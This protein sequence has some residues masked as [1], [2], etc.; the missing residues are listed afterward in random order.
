MKDI[1][2]APFIQETV[3]TAANMYRLGWDERNSGN[4]SLL[5]DRQQV[6]AYLDTDYVI[7]TIPMPF[8]A[9]E[10]AGRLFL[11]TGT[12]KYFKNMAT[13]DQTVLIADRI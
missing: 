11:V 12:G 5:L 7:R 2:T 13:P 10:L 9:Q 4:I 1:L 3:N 8:Q 6:S